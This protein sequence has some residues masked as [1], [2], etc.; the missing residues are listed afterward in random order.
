MSV[1]LERQ[2]REWWV[3]TAANLPEVDADELIHRLEWQLVGESEATRWPGPSN[4]W[5]G[6]LVAGA[7]AAAVALLIGG[8]AVVASLLGE[9]SRPVFDQ[10]APSVPAPVE[11]PS[12]TV[13][14]PAPQDTD[15]GI[16]PPVGSAQ[17]PG[18]WVEIPRRMNDVIGGGPGFVA[19]GSSEQG[20]MVWSSTDGVEWAEQYSLE[21]PGGYIAGITTTPSGLVAVGA[22]PCEISDCRTVAA[23]WTSPDGFT[24][25]IAYQMAESSVPPGGD[26]S[27]WGVVAYED[28]VVAT[29]ESCPPEPRPCLTEVWTSLDGVTWSPTEWSGNDVSGGIGVAV[30]GPGLIATGQREDGPELA[31]AVW[32]SEDGTTWNSVETEGLESM[33]LGWVA[34]RG[35][36]LIA[37]SSGYQEVL[38]SFDGIVWSQVSAGDPFVGGGVIRDLLTL[39]DGR[40]VAVGS[41]CEG[42]AIW[43][44]Q[45]GNRWNPIFLGSGQLRA[46][47]EA[48]SRLVA[49]GSGRPILGSNWRTVLIWAAELDSISTTSESAEPTGGCQ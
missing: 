18:T 5:R 13:A 36:G 47:A 29:S 21:A 4:L 1:D 42:A 43:I 14:T 19:T 22:L 32:L 3:A 17:L 6:W 11:Q 20:P 40:T 2:V 33:V 45:D 26:T 16:E 34:A 35:Q 30:G 28:T 37:V 48:G 10:P 15:A 24:W 31:G 25:E 7:A 23:A 41:T 38:T 8:V 12:S 46:V 27:M 9:E 39:D 44:S 49:V